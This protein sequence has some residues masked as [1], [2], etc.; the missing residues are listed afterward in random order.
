MK[1]TCTRDNLTKAL[2]IVSGI[3]NKSVNLPI[4][5]NVLIKADDQK[6]ELIATNLELAI[7]VHVRSKVDEP[8]S[9]TVPAKTLSEFVGLLSE[10]RYV[11]CLMRFFQI[12]CHVLFSVITR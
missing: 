8:G 7:V 9:F 3:A 11:G 10:K 6:T 1:I 2:S 5:G 12:L 4:L